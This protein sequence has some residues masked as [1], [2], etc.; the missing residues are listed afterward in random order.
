MRDD[1]LLVHG[2]WCV[3]RN[4]LEEPRRVVSSKVRDAARCNTTLSRTEVG[5]W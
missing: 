2:G 5:L 4:L 1:V 3:N